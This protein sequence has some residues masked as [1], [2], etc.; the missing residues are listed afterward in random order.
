MCRI[1][2]LLSVDLGKHGFSFEDMKS[3]WHVDCMVLVH[4]VKV[5]Y[6]HHRRPSQYPNGVNYHIVGHIC[7]GLGSSIEKKVPANKRNLNL[8]SIATVSDVKAP[9][10][11]ADANCYTSGC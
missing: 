7:K 5:C 6:L 9:L 10:T 11:K 3:P 4:T 8:Q 1:A 2:T